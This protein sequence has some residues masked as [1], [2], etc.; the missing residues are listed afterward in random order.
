MKFHLFPT[1]SLAVCS[2]LFVLPSLI[3]SAFAEHPGQIQI[4]VS[5]PHSSSQTEA[6]PSHDDSNNVLK[7]S[8]TDFQKPDRS[9][10]KH[11]RKGRTER[12]VIID[13]SSLQKEPRRRRGEWNVNDLGINDNSL[14]KAPQQSSVFYIEKE[15]GTSTQVTVPPKPIIPNNRI[16]DPLYSPYYA[17][18]SDK[19]KSLY[20]QFYEAIASLK[21]EIVIDDYDT[22][23]KSYARVLDAIDYDHPEIFW[24]KST[25][26]WIHSSSETGKSI[27]F[28][29]NYNQFADNLPYYRALLDA[30]AEKIVA[31][32]RKLTRTIDQELYVYE[33]MT[34]NIKYVDDS[35]ENQTIYGALI[36]HETVCAGFAKTFQLIMRKL[37]V[38][39]YYLSGYRTDYMQNGSSDTGPHAWNVIMI[40]GK[41]YNVDLI[42]GHYKIRTRSN[43]EYEYQ[44]YEYFNR[45]DQFFKDAGYDF[46]NV[47]SED[48]FPVYPAAVSTDAD[49]EHGIG[50]ELFIPQLAKQYP[51]TK[52]NIAYNYDD[53]IKHMQTQLMKQNGLQMTTYTIFADK[54]TYKKAKEASWEIKE[55]DFLT[56]VY[57][58]KQI[59]AKDV[60]MK[61]TELTDNFTLFIEK[62]TFK[63]IRSE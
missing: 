60:S 45:T 54:N 32:A 50:P 31:E 40:D 59:D 55:R 33:Y 63:S 19:E 56:P 61:S 4:T 12:F 41:S 15:N 43:K 35:E 53:Y 18:L 10:V 39:T 26:C 44:S 49:V 20:K 29:F 42:G 11:R 7:I 24:H 28:E 34:K 47:D 27:S 9:R 1:I 21:K 3:S 51:V 52:E 8:D 16:Y 58:A 30:E 2:S 57:Q 37:G 5:E 23:E 14:K 25:T 48:L 13:D 62:Y 38:P 6:A 46:T 17:S 22:A 36:N